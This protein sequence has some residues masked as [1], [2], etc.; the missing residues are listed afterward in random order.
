MQKIKSVLHPHQTAKNDIASNSIDKHQETDSNLKNHVLESKESSTIKHHLPSKQSSEVENHLRSEDS[1]DFKH[2]LSSNKDSS[3]VKTNPS[4]KD[5]EAIK[6]NNQTSLEQKSH[7]KEPH[8]STVDSST[9]RK[10]TG[11]G[12]FP[13]AHSQGHELVE[14]AGVDPTAVTQDESIVAPVTHESIQHQETEE[15][16]RARQH[17]RHIHHL[18]HH[19]QP[20]QDKEIRDEV[21]HSN[22]LPKTDLHESHANTK[23]DSKAFK[24][25]GN[26]FENQTIDAGTTRSIV[27][28][29]EKTNTV[30]HHHIHNV[31]QPVIEKE[32]HDRHRIHTTVPIHHVTHEA[33]IVHQSIQHQPLNMKDFLQRG[34]S[35]SKADTHLNISQ[36][37]LRERSCEREVNGDGFKILENKGVRV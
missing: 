17:D 6:H 8:H 25:I 37:V 1:L 18:Q 34:G 13:K 30:E 5:S 26:Q 32:T 3:A 28:L 12:D 33:P 23:E 2:H 19:V 36:K 10:V 35:F 27:D 4:V 22:V 7:L 29:G 15:V 11:S 21:H 31:I 24:A 20:V 9:P 16:L 14:N